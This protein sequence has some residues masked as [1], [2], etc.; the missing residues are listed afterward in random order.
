MIRHNFADKV[1]HWIALRSIFFRKFC[2]ARECALNDFVPDCSRR[3][4][5]ISGMA[6][7]GSTSIL[8]VIYGTGKFSSTTYEMM[9]F[10]F[11]LTVSK[12]ISVLNNRSHIPLERSHG[13]NIEVGLSSAEALDGVFWST[14]FPVDTTH[15]QPRRVP[16][17]I[18]QH[19]ALFIE[20]I[21][22]TKQSDRYLAKMNQGID[23]LHSLIAY[24]NQSVFLIPFRQ[25]VFQSF[26]LLRQHERF[27]NLDWYE[28]KYFDWLDHFEFGEQHKGFYEKERYVNLENAKH[29]TP[30]DVN[31]WLVQWL[32]SYTYL[33]KLAESNE[34]VI[35]VQYEQLAA[36]Q[37]PW[38]CL[39]D[40][41]EVDLCGS[42]FM[43]RNQVEKCSMD[44]V[45]ATILQNCMD[46]YHKLS[47]LTMVKL[48]SA[49]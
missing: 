10:I 36:S 4:V 19:Y 20:S 17:D 34:T 28:K 42:D 27:S 11:S 23:K 7:S 16:L 13:D 43:N 12:S 38:N 22:Y 18:L 48:C 9:P 47:E 6:R 21:L 24:F 40:K 44:D 49:G 33:L 32:N 37:T 31:Y 46:V 30:L 39:S 26:S 5:F 8:N 15:V 2:F 3:N 35:P 29:R 45:D 14:F 41:L 1:L 25:P